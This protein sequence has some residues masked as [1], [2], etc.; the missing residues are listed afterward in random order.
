MELVEL[1]AGL[2]IMLYGMGGTFLF[3]AFMYGVMVLLGKY[4]K[5]K[6]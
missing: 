1:M 2:E 6:E 5:D 3:A 4:V